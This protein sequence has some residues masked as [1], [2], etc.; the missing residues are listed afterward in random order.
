MYFAELHFFFEST[1]LIIMI[2]NGLNQDQ[3]AKLDDLIFNLN[4][5]NADL[6]YFGACKKLTFS[7]KIQK[8]ASIMKRKRLVN[9]M[10][11]LVKE[12]RTIPVHMQEALNVR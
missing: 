1:I 5:L 6:R 7:E 8:M 4:S 11:K 2:R 3:Q 10:R 12:C 9:K